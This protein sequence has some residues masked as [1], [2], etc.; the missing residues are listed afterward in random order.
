MRVYRESDKAVDW[1]YALYV[2]HTVFETV[3]GLMKMRG[4]YAGV[5]MALGAEKF[6]RH[7]GVALLA[8]AALGGEVL[9]R[10]LCHTT[11][12]EVA[13][14]ALTVFHAGAAAVMMHAAAFKTVALHVPFAVGFARHA[15]QSQHT[16]ARSLAP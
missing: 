3:L 12:G 2:V 7:H 14:S 6:A 4:T 1:V 9:R 5:T 10:K 15:W 8:L 13:S 11:T 16:P